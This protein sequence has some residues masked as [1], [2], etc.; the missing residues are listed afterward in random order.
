MTDKKLFNYNL[1][2]QNCFSENI[3]DNIPEFCTANLY[4][5]VYSLALKFAKKKVDF[6][7]LE[8]DYLKFG[9]VIT[10][11]LKDASVEINTLL[12]EDSEFYHVHS[13]GFFTFT[14]GEVVVLGSSHLLALTAY[15]ATMQKIPCNAVLTEPNFESVLSSKMQILLNG[16]PLVVDVTPFKSVVCDMEIINKCS[17]ESLSESYI[18]TVSKLITLIDYKLRVY[19]DRVT[20]NKDYYDKVKRAIQLVIAINNYQNPKEVLV[21]AQAVIA[22][23]NAESDM[24]IDG[25]VELFGDTLGIFAPDFTYGDRLMLAFSKLV[26]IYHMFFNN[27]FSDL[28][29]LP[30]YNQDIFLLEKSTGKS[31]KYFRK[32]LKIPSERRLQLLNALLF[33]TKDAFKKE[34]SSLLSVLFAIE[35]IYSG[36]NK[37]SREKAVINYDMI[38]NSLTL[39][40]YFSDKSSVLTLCRDMGI[41]RCLQW[42]KI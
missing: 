41:L 38:K 30:D 36:L 11:A 20:F 24:L 35:K 29:S 10:K 23:V 14:G 34:T 33:K 3:G 5:A 8:S 19:T 7:S 18:R 4:D 32:K 6:V 12:I 25:A 40:T 17:R 2:M 26:K 16:V 39:C 27:D 28:I 13:K 15:Y 9:S 42:T 31:G 22:K 1:E 37:P 21:Y